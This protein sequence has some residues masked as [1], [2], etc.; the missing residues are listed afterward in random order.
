[1]LTSAVFWCLVYWEII[2]IKVPILWFWCKA[3]APTQ[4][5]HLNECSVY[6]GSTNLLHLYSLLASLSFSLLPSPISL[7]F[8]SLLL[9]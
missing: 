1:M 8:L 6:T 5:T 9:S 7:P 2:K 3:N 4:E